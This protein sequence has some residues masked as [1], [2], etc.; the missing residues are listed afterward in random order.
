MMAAKIGKNKKEQ[1][2]LLLTQP[3][4]LLTLLHGIYNDVIVIR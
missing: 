3:L 2:M 4:L 1:S